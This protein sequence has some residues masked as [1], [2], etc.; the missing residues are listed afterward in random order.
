VRSRKRRDAQASGAAELQGLNVMLVDDDV[1]SA[2]AL[3]GLLERQGAAVS[4][5]EDLSEALQRLGECG[6][7]SA[8]LIDA[9][10]LVSS[11]EGSLRHVLERC[12]RLPII[13]LTGPHLAAGEAAARV[14]SEVHRLAKPVDGAEL[15]SLLRAVAL[16]A[17]SMES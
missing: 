9:E 6:G 13:A 14:P 4:H 8:L 5:A 1:R 3:T 11:S 10:L 7:S 15:L 2:F 16:Q 12:G 17:K